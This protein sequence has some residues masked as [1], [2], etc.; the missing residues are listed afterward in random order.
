MSKHN[1]R[2]YKTWVSQMG[3][4]D[5]KHCGKVGGLHLVSEYG[6]DDARV[7]DSVYYVCNGCL[8]AMLNR[9]L[10]VRMGGIGKTGKGSK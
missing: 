9:G 3:G 4:G 1:G 2:W 6:E 7:P 5:C 8:S 10:D